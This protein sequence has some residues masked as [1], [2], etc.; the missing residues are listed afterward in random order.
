MHRSGTGLVS[1]LLAGMGVFMG[2]DLTGNR[3]SRAMQSINRGVLDLLGASWR[4]LEHWP[5]VDD[6]SHRMPDLH[7]WVRSQWN[8]ARPAFLGGQTVDG[9]W[10]W[11]DPRNCLTLPLWRGCFPAMR[12]VHVLRDGRACAASLYRRESRNRPEAHWFQGEARAQRFKRDV[13]LWSQYIARCREAAEGLPVLELRYEQ[14]QEDPRAALL[15]L[16]E[17]V[18][19]S[20]ETPVL[21]TIADRVEPERSPWRDAVPWAVGLADHHPMLSPPKAP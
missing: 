9:P 6:L 10:G 8:E 14:L 17:F 3:E 15:A 2:S 1:D 18:G 20:L 5:E 7:R 13:E 19:V 16:A 4:S 21:K 12:V 11:K